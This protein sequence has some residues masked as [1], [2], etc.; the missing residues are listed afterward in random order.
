MSNHVKVLPANEIFISFQIQLNQ[1]EPVA[2]KKQPAEPRA[3]DQSS[4]NRAVSMRK[5]EFVKAI[6]KNIEI[7]GGR[8]RIF[9]LVR[10]AS[11]A[12]SSVSAKTVSEPLRVEKR[13]NGSAGKVAVGF[14]ECLI[15]V[16]LLLIYFFI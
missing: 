4:I 12:S 10:S 7:G 8:E 16:V 15:K 5:Q 2:R 3:Q 11:P 14:Y 9:G 6:E 1:N 13:V